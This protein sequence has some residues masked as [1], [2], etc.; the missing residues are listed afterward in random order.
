MMC[1]LALAGAVAALALAA[2][3]AAGTA[4]SIPGPPGK[5]VFTSGRPSTGVEAPNVGDAA[6]RI[7]VA[8]F[9]SGIPVQVT[10]QPEGAT[11]RHRQP[12]W[13]PDHSRIAYAAGSGTSFALWI[14]DLRTGNQT[15]IIPPTTGLDRP[16]WS[17]DGTQSPTGPKATSG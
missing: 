3:P 5:I 8:D 6:S 14:L 12:N 7:F 4:T 10:T 13:S 17:P 11:I 1:R 2:F 9:P 15:Q 16:T